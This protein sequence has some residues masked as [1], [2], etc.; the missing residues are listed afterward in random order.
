MDMSKTEIRVDLLGTSFSLTVDEDPVY[1]QTIL[2]QYRMI[3]ENTQ[4]TTGIRDPLKAAILAGFQLCD[5]LEKRRANE[6]TGAAVMQSRA[7]ERKLLDLIEQI[8]KALPPKHED[9]Q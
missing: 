1:L 4:K 7:A 8:D 6:K 3:I 5:E 9:G 2:T